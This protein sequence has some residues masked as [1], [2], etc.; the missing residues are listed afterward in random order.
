MISRL[1]KPQLT[2]TGRLEVRSWWFKSLTLI[3]SQLLPLKWYIRMQQA[4]I[5]ASKR[6]Y[7]AALNAQKAAGVVYL[8]TLA[9][10]KFAHA[11]YVGA[12]GAYQ[13]VR[14]WWPSTELREA[15]PRTE[16]SATH[17]HHDLNHIAC[18]ST[19]RH[20]VAFYVDDNAL[21][22]CHGPKR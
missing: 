8:K 12:M 20:T 14:R 1:L 2:C 13:K 4:A 3:P 16:V 6:A 17:A 21:R 9:A 15:V 22:L 18:S 10:Y 7:V 5:N 11:K 19:R